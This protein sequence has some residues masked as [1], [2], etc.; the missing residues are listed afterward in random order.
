[1]RVLKQL[2]RS[3]FNK[4]GYRIVRDGSL[5]HTSIP[6]PAYGLEPFFSLLK[7]YRF[8]PKHII[9]VGANKGMWTRRALPFFPD[10]HYTLVEP[11]DHLKVHI[12]DLLD[13]GCKITWI[14]AGVADHSGTLPFAIS[15]RDDS[16]TFA[17]TTD[18]VNAPHISVRV[19][20]LNEIVS[21]ASAPRPGMVKIDAEGFDL[22]VLAGASDVLGKTEIFFVEVAVCSS[23]YEN[24]I[25]RV[26]DRMDQAGYKVV[27]ITDIN[28]SPKYGVLWLSELA[29]LRNDSSLLD[30]VASYE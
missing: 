4:F 27:D 2:I 11:Q 17:P 1:M 28:R 15:Y 22:K 13:R 9:D 19:T 7:R 25:A 10:A 24:T 12:Q 23:G 26:I 3:T 20:T 5:P 21:L 14:N 6:P 18:D 8:N 30:T 16:S 29:F